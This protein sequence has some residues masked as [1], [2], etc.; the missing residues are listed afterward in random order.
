MEAAK[1]AFSTALK[2]NPEF[3]GIGY[4]LGAMHL[5]DGN[6][7]AASV[8]FESEPHEVF[9]KIGLA[10]SY[11]AQGEVEH[12]DRFLGE[13]IGGYGER[14]SFYLAEI[15]AFRGDFDDAFVWLA[16]ARAIND[17]ELSNVHNEPL[18]N[19]LHTDP[20]WLPF[21]E[22]VGQSESSLSRI[23]FKFELPE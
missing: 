10:M 6:I 4:E 8:A 9:K 17:F 15:M 5:M 7:L 20:R 16:K 3:I 13:L 22:S 11:Y 2:L 18:L 19:N 12:S 14:L 1:E 23:Q 21:L